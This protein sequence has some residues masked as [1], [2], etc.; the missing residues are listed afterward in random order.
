MSWNP[1]GLD[2]RAIH[3][4]QDVHAVTIE[5]GD[6]RRV[7]ASKCDFA[8]P[9]T[10]FV[11]IYDANR[12]N[13]PLLAG[14]HDVLELLASDCLRATWR[15]RRCLPG[16][17]RPFQVNLGERDSGHEALMVDFAVGRVET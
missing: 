9:I 12:L 17:G 6:I 7:F 10:M 16:I 13:V 15:Q 8:K 4:D 2:R 14:G 5:Y 11:T 3:Q 1:F